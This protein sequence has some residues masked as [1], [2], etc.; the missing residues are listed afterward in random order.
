MRTTSLVSLLAFAG[1][2]TGSVAVLRPAVAPAPLSLCEGAPVV[3]AGEAR[4]QGAAPSR[5]RDT[6]EVTY[7]GVS[8]FL[9]R[10]GGRTL[11]T[12]PSIT[13]PRLSVVVSGWTIRP[14][15]ALV[16]RALDGLSLDS[17]AAV[18]V[19]HAHYDHLLDVPYV[20]RRHAPRATIYGGPTVR[21][22]LQGDS[23]LRVAGRVRSVSGAEVGT[24]TRAGRWIDLPGGGIRV[25]A[26]ESS[27]APNWLAFTLAPGGAERDAE[28]LPRSAWGWKL[29]EPY[30][31]LID[32]MAAD[33][34]PAFRILF[35]DAAAEPRYAGLPP[36]ADPRD[37]RPVDLAIVAA[38]NFGKADDY[39]TAHLQ[40]LMPRHVL[41]GHWEDFFRSPAAPRRAIPLTR[42]DE[43]ARRLDAVV[44][45][46]WTTLDVRGRLRI[47]Y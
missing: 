21:R 31:W 15:T 41:V 9:I 35:Q 47:A 30:A 12:A 6:V 46:R 36:F 10:A 43:L 19:G 27:H 39:P 25:M 8:G 11:L 45:G 23:A 44:P 14:D 4:G 40:A 38:G 20:A 1:A 22:L 18:L 33:S 29:G 42:T 34:T 7:L 2:C 17:A 5:C 26:L 37:R 13:H 3:L 24:T 28:R 16:D 32:V